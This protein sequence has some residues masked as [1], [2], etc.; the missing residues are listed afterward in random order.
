NQQRP[1]EVELFFDRQRPRVQE[2]IGCNTRR[3]VVSRIRCKKHVAH[4]ERTCPRAPR[5][6]AQLFRCEKETR[7]QQARK[8]DQGGGWTQPAYS[9]RIELQ[10]IEPG[11]PVNLAYQLPRDQIP[12]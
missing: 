6:E 1:E 10:Q 9:A 7:C 3:E 11:G 8:Q 4:I 5:G 2:W 12:R